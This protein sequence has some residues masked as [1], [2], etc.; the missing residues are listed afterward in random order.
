M[1][2]AEQL[3]GPSWRGEAYR[4][5]GAGRF[6]TVHPQ[7]M[8]QDGSSLDRSGRDGLAAG[9]SYPQNITGQTVQKRSEQ[10]GITPGAAEVLSGG[11]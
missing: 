6:R 11:T 7:V 8:S 10:K 3:S 4:S 5:S 1:P 2:E 9:Q